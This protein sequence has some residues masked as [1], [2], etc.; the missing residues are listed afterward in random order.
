MVFHVSSSRRARAPGARRRRGAARRARADRVLRHLRLPALPAV[1]GRAAAGAPAPATGRYARRRALRI[2]P[3]YWVALTVLAVYPGDHG[4][5][6]RRLVALLPF[7][8]AYDARTLGLGIPVAWTLCVEVAFYI[9]LPFWALLVRRLPAGRRPAG[10]AADRSCSRSGCRPAPRSPSRSPRA[11]RP[12]RTSLAQSLLGQAAW[13]G[14]GMAIAVVSV[15][16]AER[17]TAALRTRSSAAT[18]ACCWS[19]R[20]R[21]S[22]RSPSCTATSTGCSSLVAT[23]QT[24]PAVRRDRRG[25]RAHRGDRRAAARTGGVR[26]GRGRLPA[27]R[28]GRGAARVARRH[29]L[30]GV[31][32]APDDRGV[33]R[34]ARDARAVRAPRAWIWPRGCRSP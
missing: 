24:P 21:P 32:L 16:P 17:R 23:L 19:G 25:H 20:S 27:P 9:A 33:P 6:H 22:P 2:L 11:V 13:L 18:R 14:L 8:Q 30:R 26:R 12:S 29:L 31:P 3:A 1:G 7:L 5:L 28:A 4:R 34:P 10:L 15:A